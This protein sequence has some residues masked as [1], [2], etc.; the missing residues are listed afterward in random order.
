MHWVKSRK[1]FLVVWKSPICQACRDQHIVVG[2]I[3]FPSCYQINTF[4]E[5]DYSHIGL[6]SLLFNSATLRLLELSCYIINYH[7]ITALNTYLK[8]S[9]ETRCDGSGV[10][11][12]SVAL[13]LARP[14]REAW[15]REEYGLGSFGISAEF[16]SIR[17]AGWLAANTVFRW[18]RP[19]A[20]LT[21]S[22]FPSI[23]SK[24]LV[25]WPPASQ[26]RQW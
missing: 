12:I 25:M 18:Y 17:L 4:T 1:I 21:A 5:W 26:L 2:F 16:I 20:F 23:Y 22:C 7:K 15:Q 6:F 24:Y 10:P 3:F 19:P 11:C 13:D 8:G 9:R 14:H